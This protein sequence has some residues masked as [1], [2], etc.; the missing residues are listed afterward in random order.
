MQRLKGRHIYLRALEPTDLEFLYQ[1]ENDPTIWEVSGTITPYSKHVLRQYLENAHRDIY[2]VKQ[3][4]LAICSLKD[5]VLGLI[6]LFDFDPQNRRAGVGIVVK[7]TA[8][9]NKGVGGEAISL[10]IDYAFATLDLRQLFANV[11]ADNEV[12]LH[13]FKKLGFSQVGVKKDW[14]FENGVYKDEILFQKINS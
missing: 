14:I 2:D 6:D 3:L 9:R 4:R 10:L 7:E 13:L 8:N 11:G 1:L 5:E 12:S